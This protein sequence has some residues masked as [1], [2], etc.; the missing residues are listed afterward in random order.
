[1]GRKPDGKPITARSTCHLIDTSFDIRSYR[2]LGLSPI[3]ETPRGL[4]LSAPPALPPAATEAA[5]LGQIAAVLGVTDSRTRIVNTPNGLRD[6]ILRRENLV[7][8]VD[9][10]RSREHRERWANRIALTLAEPLEVWL[11]KVPRRDGKPVF[12]RRFIA[13]FDDGR[14]ALAV[15]DENKDS[16]VLW[17][18]FPRRKLDSQRKGHLLYRKGERG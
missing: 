1:M 16:S 4:V 18:F 11:V 7:H 10:E 9:E 5:A 13:A 15:A 2:D 14:R 6:V 12:R 3:A 8:L 17:T